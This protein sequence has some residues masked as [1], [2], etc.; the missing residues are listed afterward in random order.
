MPR[1]SKRW[2][3]LSEEAMWERLARARRSGV[4]VAAGS[5]AGFMLE[6]GASNAGEIELL[7]QGGYSPLEA[8]CA[9]TA[10]GADILEIDAGRLAPGKLADLV[11][12]AGDPLASIEFLRKRENLRVF[13]GGREVLAPTA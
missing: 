7:V 3:E 4:K 6:H 1:G 5:D 11:L 10:T 8:I 2:A 12:V 13:K 9:A